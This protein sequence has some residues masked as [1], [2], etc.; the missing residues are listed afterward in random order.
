MNISEYEAN[1]LFEKTH[2]D[3][4]RKFSCMWLRANQAAITAASNLGL[5]FTKPEMKCLLTVICYD[6]LDEVLE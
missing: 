5:D 2:N 4:A 6:I 1:R 3:G